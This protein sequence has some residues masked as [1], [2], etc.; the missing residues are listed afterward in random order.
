MRCMVN[1]L[2]TKILEEKKTGR[3]GVFDVRSSCP[4]MWFSSGFFV[5]IFVLLNIDQ[6]CEDLASEWEWCKYEMYPLSIRL[7]FG[8]RVAI[9]SK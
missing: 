9:D 7:L 6:Y 4:F 1:Q 5:F 3:N 2:K 8:M